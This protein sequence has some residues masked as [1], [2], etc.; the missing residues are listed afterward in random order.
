MT[1]LRFS[2]PRG[3]SRLPGSPRLRATSLLAA[4]LL[5]APA[6]AGCQTMDTMLG[7][8]ADGP[9]DC[10]S[11]QDDPPR[12]D[13]P[14]LLIYLDISDNSAESASRISENLRPYFEGALREGQYI[15]LLASGGGD[16]GLTSSDC[17]DGGALFKID[18]NNDTREEKDRNAAVDALTEEV[19]HIVQSERVS[20]TGSVTKLLSGTNDEIATLRA[21]PGARIG[22]VTVVVWTDLLGSGE[23]SDCLN[24]DGKKASVQIAEAMVR[25]CFSPEAQQ[26]TP[27]TD[28]KVRFIGVN[29]GPATKPQQDIARYLKG[30]LCRRISSDCG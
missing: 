13:A 9:I 19:D 12:S 24:V 6:L 17:L 7:K 28:G 20:P 3:S 14:L 23:A 5:A 26:L 15:R 22:A 21:A 27:I 30:E 25:R 29:A 1:R 10:T 8:K 16:A 18:R 4:A 2:R 11:Y